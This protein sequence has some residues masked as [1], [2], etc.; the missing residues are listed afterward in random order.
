M[1]GRKHDGRLVDSSI[2]SPSGE[3]RPT[4][5]GRLVLDSSEGETSSK[6]D[7]RCGTISSE[8]TQRPRL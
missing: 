1:G 7:K 2:F 5:E 4:G 6:K 8:A 3:P